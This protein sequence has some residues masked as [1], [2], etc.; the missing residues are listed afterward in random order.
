MILIDIVPEI[1]AHCAAGDERTGARDKRGELTGWRTGCAECLTSQSSDL[2]GG[3][4]RNGTTDPIV[5]KV[6]ALPKNLGS[7]RLTSFEWTGSSRVEDLAAEVPG[8]NER[9]SGELQ[10]H[11]SSGHV[12]HL[13]PY[14]PSLRWARHGQ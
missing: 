13:R 7:R 12:E 14:R 3:Q 6:N 2:T 8:L 10:V 11:G 4:G 5:S 1:S 9:C